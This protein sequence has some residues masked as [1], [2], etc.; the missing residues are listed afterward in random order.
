MLQL[1]K[2]VSIQIGQNFRCRLENVK[3]SNAYVIQM[4]DLTEDNRLNCDSLF[5]I[6]ID[7]INGKYLIKKN[8][9]LF[10]SRGKTNTAVLVDQEVA[11]TVVS[12]PLYRIRVLTNNVTPAYLCWFINHPSSQL[13]FAKMAKGT[14]VQMIDKKTLGELKIYVPSLDI[15]DKVVTLNNLSNKEQ[16]IIKEILNKRQIYMDAFLMKLVSEQR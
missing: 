6:D 14:S 15:Q 11:Y 9:I 7:E 3:K 13:Y 5:G 16:K 1:K 4:K 12:S 8:D 10:R 2:M